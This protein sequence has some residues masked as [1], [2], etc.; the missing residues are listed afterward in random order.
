MRDA[1]E[2]EAWWWLLAAIAPVPGDVRR[3]WERQEL[4]CDLERPVFW[5]AV[6][7]SGDA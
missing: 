5:T 2:R 1:S 6:R 4:Q 7:E 3:T